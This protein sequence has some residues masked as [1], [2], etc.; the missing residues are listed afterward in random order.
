[1]YTFNRLFF[2]NGCEILKIVYSG[3][4]TVGSSQI[5]WHLANQASKITNFQKVKPVV[6]PVVWVSPPLCHRNSL[7]RHT[8]KSGLFDTTHV[9]LSHQGPRVCSL[10][11]FDTKGSRKPSLKMNLL[12]NSLIVPS[13]GSFPISI[14]QYQILKRIYEADLGHQPLN[15]LGVSFLRGWETQSSSIFGAQCCPDNPWGKGAS[16]KGSL[17]PRVFSPVSLKV[18]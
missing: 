9:Q 11:H 10:C 12:K 7:E 13:S 6:K 2:K 3:H 18:Q 17:D 4:G 5:K 8:K 15:L 16:G 1:M 14:Q